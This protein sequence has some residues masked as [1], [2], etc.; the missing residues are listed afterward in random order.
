MARGN[1]AREGRAAKSELSDSLRAKA[2]EL[3][4]KNEDE[5]AEAERNETE[6]DRAMKS[7]IMRAEEEVDEEFKGKRLEV[8]ED[9]QAQREAEAKKA[10]EDAKAEEEREARENA[11][12]EAT[13]E[14]IKNDFSGSSHPYSDYGYIDSNWAKAGGKTEDKD[15]VNPDVNIPIEQRN[16]IKQDYIDNAVKTAPKWMRED[17]KTALS[18]FSLRDMGN[19]VSR[20]GP[21]D[22]I[23]YETFG[24]TFDDIYLRGAFG[25]DASKA[26]VKNEGVY[27]RWEV[28]SPSGG[29]PTREQHT[30][31]MEAIKKYDL[32]LA[33]VLSGARKG[34]HTERHPQYDPNEE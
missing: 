20:T 16:F 21:R 18:A 31:G 2:R 11:Q 28:K 26:E 15:A 9:E 1:N 5:R 19:L 33:K 4:R 6:Y 12:K 22:F 29:T 32:Y 13:E 8:D 25:K 14:V 7:A 30:K 10:Q 3:L 27:G 17:L 24:F 23:P 34:G